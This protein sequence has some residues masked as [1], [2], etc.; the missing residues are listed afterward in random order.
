MNQSFQCAVVESGTGSG[1]LTTSLA[2][3]VGPE[4]AVHTFEFHEQR[5]RAAAE[6]FSQLGLDSTVHLKQRDIEGQG[7]PAELT[8]QA[9][10]VFLDLPGP[11]KV[12]NL[13]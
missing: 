6:D 2:R 13:K 11:W 8:G 3:A 7:F 5:C 4:G 9:D 10:A 1:S 12:K